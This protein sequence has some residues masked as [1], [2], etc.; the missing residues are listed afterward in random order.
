MREEGVYASATWANAFMS[1]DRLTEELK[2]AERPL[3]DIEMPLIH[4]LFHMEQVGI[5]AER[6]WLKEYGDR[7]R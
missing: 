5:K 2:K 3:T 4:S 7:Q 6:E 1:A